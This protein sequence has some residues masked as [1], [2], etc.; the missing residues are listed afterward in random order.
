MRQ[1]SAIAPPPLLGRAELVVDHDRHAFAGGQFG[2]HLLQVLPRAEFGG[3]GQARPLAKPS[4]ILAEH[5]DLGDS[6]RL[7]LARKRGHRNRS[8]GVLAAGHGHSIVVQDLERDVDAGGD[9]GLHRQASRV[10]VGAV[11]QILEQV[12]GAGERGHAD[13]RRTLRAHLEQELDASADIAHQS[14]HSVAADSAAGELPLEQQGR[15]VVRAAGTVARRAGAPSR[16]QACRRRVLLRRTLGKNGHLREEP[17]E[18][19]RDHLGVELARSGQQGLAFGV[20]LAVH[21]GTMRAVV[22]QLPQL[23]FDERALLLDHHDGLEVAGE[24][25]DDAGLERKGHPELEDPDAGARQ[26]ALANAEH[27]QG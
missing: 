12:L 14:S 13:P 7:E 16:E 25:R 22:E 11:T 15:P 27:P 26:F 6:L 5:D 1:D 8:G 23:Q 24:F 4:G 18:R 17:A 3:L 2:K 10:K 19:Q 21:T 20:P 9:R